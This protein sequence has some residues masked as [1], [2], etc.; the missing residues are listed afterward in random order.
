MDW[1]VLGLAKG[2]VEK[3]VEKSK[4]VGPVV[5]DLFPQNP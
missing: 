5:I 1:G 2:G 3:K 4:L